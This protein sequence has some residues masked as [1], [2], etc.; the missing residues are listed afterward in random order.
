MGYS[1]E[2]WTLAAHASWNKKAQQGVVV[3]GLN[4]SVK[5]LA[6]PLS[7]DALV[8]LTIRLTTAC[9]SAVERDVVVLCK[10]GLERAQFHSSICCTPLSK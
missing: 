10:V 3:L 2:F 8:L 6:D 7:L 4:K 1:V 9:G 5:E